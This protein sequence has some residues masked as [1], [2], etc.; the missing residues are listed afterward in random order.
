MP[1]QIEYTEAIA[2]TICDR[3]IEGESLRKICRD[4][5]IPSRSTILRWLDSLP[6]F[7]AKYARAR[8]YQA[9]TMDDLILECA[10]TVDNDNF[11]AIKVK[12]AAYTWRAAKLAPKKYGEKVQQEVTG[13]NGGPLQ[14]A[15][16]VTFVKPNGPS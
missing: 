1:A 8:A 3:L 10:E 15:V 14:A 12:M 11:Q 16:T 9:D 5:A 6:E 4:E 2:D 13:A 7:E